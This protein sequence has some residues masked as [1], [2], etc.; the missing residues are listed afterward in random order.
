[1]DAT[2]MVILIGILVVLLLVGFMAAWRRD[3]K[4]SEKVADN[5]ERIDPD[6]HG[7]HNDPADRR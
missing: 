6:P 5:P 7:T 4:R 2:G 1:M 3:A